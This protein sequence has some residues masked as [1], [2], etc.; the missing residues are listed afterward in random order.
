MWRTHEEKKQENSLR[1]GL[2]A[3]RTVNVYLRVT[4]IITR[5][6]VMLDFPK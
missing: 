3:H 1:A 6:S 2:F 5:I 4:T